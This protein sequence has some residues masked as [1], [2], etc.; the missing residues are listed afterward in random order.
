LNVC[1]VRKVQLYSRQYGAIEVAF[2]VKSHVP[3]TN[4]QEKRKDQRRHS[5][6]IVD[7][8]HTH[9]AVD[10][11]VLLDGVKKS[12]LTTKRTDAKADARDLEVVPGMTFEAEKRWIKVLHIERSSKVVG[13]LRVDGGGRQRP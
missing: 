5:L 9:A 7:S 11:Y 2:E 12:R 6:R 3:E 13:T 4:D 1:S 8:Q 10:M